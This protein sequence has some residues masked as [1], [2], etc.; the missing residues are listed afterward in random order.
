MRRD[1]LNRFG[2]FQKIVTGVDGSA[3]SLRALEQALQLGKQFS[4]ELVLVYVVHIPVTSYSYDVLG[5]L[6]IFNKLEEDGKQTLAKCAEMASQAG[7]SARTVLL[8]GDPAQGVLDTATKEEADLLV[9]G[10]RGTGTLE[11]L[12]I[13]SVSEKVVRFSK[14]PVLVVK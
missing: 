3:N 7:V 4:S 10:S 14:C 11:R 1:G 13:G 9:V 6:S 2:M 8:S 12:L 5:S